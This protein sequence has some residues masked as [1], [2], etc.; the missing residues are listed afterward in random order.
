MFQVDELV[1]TAFPIFL[2]NNNPRGF[3]TGIFCV[4]LCLLEFKMNCATI[5]VG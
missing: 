4:I 2:D 1:H 3:V 5:F